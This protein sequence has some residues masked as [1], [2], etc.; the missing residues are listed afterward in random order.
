MRIVLQRHHLVHATLL[1]LR[2]HSKNQSI[3]SRLQYSLSTR[4]L[5]KLRSHTRDRTQF[6]INQNDMKLFKEKCGFLYF[7][8]CIGYRFNCSINPIV[9]SGSGCS[10]IIMRDQF[11]NQV[12]NAFGQRLQSACSHSTVLFFFLFVC[13]SPSLSLCYLPSITSIPAASN[14]PST[15]CTFNFLI[16][17]SPRVPASIRFMALVSAYRLLYNI[18]N[19][20]KNGSI[21][22]KK[23]ES[24]YQDFVVQ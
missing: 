8:I 15:L 22:E 21:R 17:Y 3:I 18:E 12:L 9:I 14:R 5:P 23:N 7:C 16:S 1:N 2:N 20:K 11:V 4:P 24:I 10:W 6:V 13:I 19:E